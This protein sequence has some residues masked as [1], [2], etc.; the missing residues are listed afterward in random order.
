ML[1]LRDSIRH[2][3]PSL[4]QL[5]R[6]VEEAPALTALILAAWQVASVLTVHLVEAVLAARASRP[7]PWPCCPQCGGGLQS[8]GFATRQVMSLF[9][10][11]RWR[12]RVGPCPQGCA[13]PQVVP[14]D[15]ALGAAAS[16]DQR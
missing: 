7:L 8:K 12:R 6:A 2:D 13:I 14:L 3:D 4:Q 15:E 5:L 10:P 11:I 9:G 1:C 16:A